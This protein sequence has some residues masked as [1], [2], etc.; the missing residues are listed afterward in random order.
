[1]QPLAVFHRTVS[2]RQHREGQSHLRTDVVAIEEPMEIRVVHGPAERRTLSIVSVTMRTPGHDDELAVG[3]LYSEGVLQSGNE[4]EQIESRGVDSEGEATGNVVR[5]HLRPETRFD[6]GRLQRHFLTSSSCGICGK[7]SLEALS[8]SG[9]QPLDG[10]D[11]RVPPRLIHEIPGRLRQLQPTFAE[12]G[13]LHGSGLCT[14]EGAFWAVREDIGRHNAVDKL[15][16]R[17]LL[18]DRVPLSAQILAVSGR[19]SFE[20]LQKAL[21]ARIP[22]VVAVGAPSSLAVET[23]LRFHL[24]LIGFAAADRFNIY[25]APERVAV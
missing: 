18:D 22:V 13:G 2:I 5:V 4:I 6:P 15:L 8:L 24:T 21:V 16:G 3:F 10:A 23:A 1:M 9:V 14:A 20:I 7:A 12:T 25:S 19:V 11:F 17:A